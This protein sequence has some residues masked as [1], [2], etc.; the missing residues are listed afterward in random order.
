MTYS[1]TGARACCNLSTCGFVM[2]CVD[3]RQIR[4]SSACDSE[5]MRNDL[6]LKWYAP[7]GFVSGPFLV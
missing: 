6:T 1:T 4:T 2:D 5:C 7:T 3:Y